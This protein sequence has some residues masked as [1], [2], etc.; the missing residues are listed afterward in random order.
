[1]TKKFCIFGD[2]APEK[3][4]PSDITLGDV[5]AFLDSLEEG[6]EAVFE[7]CSCGGDVFQGIAIANLIAQARREGHKTTAHVISIAASIASVICC[8]CDTIEL[9]SN[10]LWMMHLPWTMVCGN[11]IDLEKQIQQLEQCRDSMVA[12]YKTKFDLDEEQIGKLLEDET[13]IDASS[14]A[15]YNFKCEIVETTA[16]FK[17]AAHMKK[18]LARFNNKLIVERIENMD[19][20]TE[21]EIVE[22]V[23]EETV[24]TTE[25]QPSET[26]SENVEEAPEEPSV[27]ELKETIRK[28][29]E[30]VKQ[31]RE[32]KDT[33]ADER[34]AKCQ[35]V[36]QNK[37]NDLKNELQA[38]DEELSKSNSMVSSLSTEL[39]QSKRELHDVS[40]ALEDKKT[41]LEKLNASVLKPAEKVDS[42]DWKKL[43]G[44][45]FTKWVNARLGEVKVTHN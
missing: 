33:T 22:E 26:T 32:E 28:L 24:E 42:D 19:K 8:A 30:E 12:F 27:E 34:V 37:I 44:K 3:V 13:W 2:I 15:A 4:N 23:V 39:E 11:S 6:D 21:N 1:M 9:D 14:V 18:S 40:A 7:V 38:K 20:E 25:E 10:A 31:L 16:D 5:K 17:I 35:S 29:E 43:N 45:D 41:A 36:F